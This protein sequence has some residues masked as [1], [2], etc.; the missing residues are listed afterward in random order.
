MLAAREE[1][2]SAAEGVPAVGA[3][4]ED[5]EGGDDASSGDDADGQDGPPRKRAKRSKGPGSQITSTRLATLSLLVA[6][7]FASTRE[8]QLDQGTLLEAVNAGLQAGEGVFSQS[9]FTAGLAQ[10]EVQNKLLLSEAGLVFQ[11]E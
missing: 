5:P 7:T 11:T 9:E 3:G 6:K 10:M 4:D 2:A 8:Q 1:D